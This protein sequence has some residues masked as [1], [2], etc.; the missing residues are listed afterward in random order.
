VPPWD[1]Q[2]PAWQAVEASL[3]GDHVARKISD[4]VDELDLSEAV[5]ERD[6]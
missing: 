1:Q 4:A 6:F 2:S 5:N 3:P